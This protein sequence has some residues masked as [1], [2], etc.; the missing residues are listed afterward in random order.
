MAFMSSATAP[1]QV[2]IIGLGNVGSGTL[3]ILHENA[4]QIREKLGFDLAVSAICS[5]S[6]LER[7]PAAARLF[8]NVLRTANWQDVVSHPGVHIVAELVAAPAS[9]P[10]SSAPP[11]ATANPSSPQTRN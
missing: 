10:T 7:P 6:L 1:I 5:R 3:T 8:P 2:G 4:R 9:R 11:S